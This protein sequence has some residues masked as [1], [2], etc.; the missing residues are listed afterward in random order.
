MA[1]DK[2]FYVTPVGVVQPYA[3]IQRPD[4]EFNDR[5]EYRI[6]L[7]VPSEQ[8]QKLIDLITK[9]HE[10]N[11]AKVKKE[12]AAKKKRPPKECDMP[13]YEDEEGN[14]IFTFKMY[15]SYDDNGTRKELSLRVYD[16]KGNRIKDVPNISGGS[17]GRVEFSLFAFASAAVGCGVKLQLSKFK[18]LKLVE[19]KGGND[20]F[21]GDD[22]ADYEGGYVHQAAP[23]DEFG[24]DEGDYESDSDDEAEDEDF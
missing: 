6:K 3:Y 21:G 15:G 14:V 4:T 9:T 16:A 24:G 18:L 1:S 11:M 20:S 5:G 19:Y 17:E 2:K 13:F 22:D 23:K 12:A 8:A 7:A 10:T